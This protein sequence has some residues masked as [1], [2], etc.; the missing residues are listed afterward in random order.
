MAPCRLGRLQIPAKVALGENVLDCGIDSAARLLDLAAQLG[1]FARCR[2]EH[3]ATIVHRA[4]E[5]LDEV[6]VVRCRSRE[7][8]E[9]IAGSAHPAPRTL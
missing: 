4:L 8:R 1:E 6:F 7:G 3:L 9:V 2:I 5:L